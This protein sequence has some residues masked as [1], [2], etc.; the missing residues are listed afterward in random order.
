MFEELLTPLVR[1]MDLNFVVV[2]FVDI[3]LHRHLF[4]VQ[5]VLSLYLGSFLIL[6]NIDFN[7]THKNVL[8]LY[9]AKAKHIF[10]NTDHTGKR[11]ACM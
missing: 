8:T 7:L 5:F 6:S 11:I 4:V 3:L 2:L 1:D 9:I 10:L